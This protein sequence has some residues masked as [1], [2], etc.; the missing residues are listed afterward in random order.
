MKAYTPLILLLFLLVG[1]GHLQVS[2][3]MPGSGKYAAMGGVAVVAKDVYSCFH[4]QAGLGF[5][6]QSA[7]GISFN[8]AYGLK[9]MST[10]S[11][12]GALLAGKGAFGISYSRFGNQLYSRQKT[13]LAYGMQLSPK[14]AMG[15]QFDML[16][17]VLGLDYGRK[18][19]FTFEGGV[20]AEIYDGLFASAHVFNP[21]RAKMA[22]YMD[23]RLPSQLS[24]GLLWSVSDKMSLAGELQKEETGKPIFK[25]GM[26]YRLLESFF[27]RAGLSTYTAETSFG[28]GYLS[29]NWSFDLSSSLHPQLGLSHHL[30]ASYRFGKKRP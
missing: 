15:V 26:E 19:L 8:N 1:S 30:S 29:E 18:N 17:T 10:Y 4:N 23:E 25:A 13:G 22:D 28:F 2:A 6:E 16:Q 20:Q 9:E 12:A 3:Q 21:I 11:I 5:L 14:I 27:M 7:L 24:F